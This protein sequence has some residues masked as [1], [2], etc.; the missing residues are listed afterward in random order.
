MFRVRSDRRSI[1]SEGE[2]NTNKNKPTIAKTTAGPNTN[3]VFFVTGLDLD[4]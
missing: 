2:A 3:K 4:T 1:A